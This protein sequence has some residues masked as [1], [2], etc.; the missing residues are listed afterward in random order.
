MGTASG[1]RLRGTSIGVRLG[2]AFLAF[3]LVLL[4]MG[5]AGLWR[6]VQ[7]DGVTTRLAT[8]NIRMERLVAAW[9]TE[10]STNLVRSLV[11]A[12]TTDPDLEQQL[13][14]ELDATSRRISQ[15]QQ[16]V[17]A[18]DTDEEGRALIDA[19]GAKRKVYLA[20]R[21][22]ILQRK[23]AGQGAE[24]L[25]MVDSAMVPAVKAYIG[26]IQAILDYYKAQV[27]AYPQTAHAS[28][29]AGRRLLLA[30]CI[31]GVLLGVLSSWLITRSITR[32]IARAVGTARQVADGDLTARIESRS[33]D[34]MGQLLRTLSDM[35]ASLR[36]LVAQVAQGAHSLADTSA[37][38][39]QGNHDLSTRTEEQ[40]TTLEET[41]GAME[42]LTATVARN[43]S[44]ADQAARFAA[45]ASAVAN[46]GGQ[47]V[48]EVVRTMDEISESSRRISDITGVIDAIAFQTNILALNA[49]VEAARAGEQGR[50]FAVVAA[51]VRNLAQR[52]AAAAKEIKALI[53][54]AAG[55]VETGT[56]LV[57]TAGG[58]SGQVVEAVQQVSAL[59]AE[60]A[61]ASREQ[62]G[63]IE[64]V[65][66]AVVQM[67]QVVQQNATL[68]EEAAAATESMK[69]QAAA[70]LELVA[71]FRLEEARGG[72]ASSPAFRPVLVAAM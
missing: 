17:E 51:E 4:V 27:D 34:E 6:I 72:D 30:L 32:P 8:V 55:K 38:I 29:E 64:Q 26:A 13:K 47:V 33:R 15:L 28:A 70:L 39:A 42:E 16:Q 19:V 68:V 12:R 53:Q 35:A 56:R 54:D 9:H 62:A 59:V 2:L 61:A 71:Q 11:L 46:R 23:K 57:R 31:A 21:A 5:L 18:L 22:E 40:A 24:A 49:A 52:S 60:I 65:N 45:D 25:R 48:S 7:L 20:A 63:G 43:S 10:T 44:H 50:G 3:T 58:A 66:T 36:R 37:Q 14:P 69:M 41:A 1:G 67:D